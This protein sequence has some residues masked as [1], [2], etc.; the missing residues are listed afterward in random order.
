M[1]S[2]GKN[3]FITENLGISK[4]RMVVCPLVRGLTTNLLCPEMCVSADESKT[5]KQVRSSRI[6]TRNV[7]AR[8]GKKRPANPKAGTARYFFVLRPLIGI[9]HSSCMIFF[10]LSSA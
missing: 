3:R 2:G 7:C 5:T 6:T 10:S 4:K 8:V 1:K 9:P